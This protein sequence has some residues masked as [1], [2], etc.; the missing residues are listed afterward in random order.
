MAAIVMAS[1]GSFGDVY[2]YIGLGRALA[3]RGHR[4][5]LALPAYYRGVVEQE[6]LTCHPMA[7]DVD[8]DDRAAIARAMDPVRGPEEIVRHWVL[9]ALRESHADL[10]A[11][12]GGAD[13]LVTHPVTFAGP[14][15]AEQRRMPW[16]S[17]V[18]APMSFFSAWDVP[19]MSAAPP[20]LGSIGR[21][22]P[23]LGRPIARLA[24]HATR[25]WLEPVTALR[26]ELGLAPGDHPLFEGQFSPVLNLA[27]FSRV[28]ATPRPDW[29]AHTHTT[30]FV[31][32]NGPDPLPPALDAFLAAGPPPVVF[33]LGSSA[34]GAAG[35]FYEES[36]QAAVAL[37]V[38]AVLLTGPVPEN[39]P[40]TTSPDVLAID[41]APHQ[42]LFPRA[43]A[44]V[45]HGGVG[46]TGQALRSGRPT[47]VVPH[48]H[49]QPDNAA[50][51]KRLGTSRTITPRAYSSARVAR[52][53]ERLLRDE[54]H[55]VA[56]AAAADIVRSEGGAEDAAQ[57]IETVL[58]R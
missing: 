35:T 1:W 2:P 19:V 16:V 42:L 12:T 20:L 49:D 54:R 58:A 17:T 22:S 24:R 23:M 39:R 5:T 14:I 28:L 25:A 9:P 27:L 53:L 38:R 26:A 57:Q 15:V 33:T 21:L 4:V 7:P 56:A 10:L 41:R 34:V 40:R 55:R 51:L 36:A 11:A 8:P 31:F 47:L 44:I 46:T 6:G 37:G 30:G 45:H 3:A 48:S 52:E 29:P 13:L 43:S 32:H 18:L 50:R